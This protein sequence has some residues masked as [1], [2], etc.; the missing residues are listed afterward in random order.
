MG[1][2]EEVIC[3]L[4]SEWGEEGCWAETWMGW[5]MFQTE[6]RVGAKAPRQAQVC[7][8][9]RRAKDGQSGREVHVCRE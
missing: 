1:L 2:L 9:G 3:E 5:G 8:V 6:H 7:Y 4:R